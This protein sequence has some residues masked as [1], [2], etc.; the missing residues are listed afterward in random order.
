MVS[1]WPDPHP[2][3]T[4]ANPSFP[5][6][7]QLRAAPTTVDHRC[8]STIGDI[9]LSRSPSLGW[10]IKAPS[11]SFNPAKLV[12]KE[13]PEWLP[14]IIH[15]ARRPGEVHGSIITQSICSSI[16]R[17][18]QASVAGRFRFVLQQGLLSVVSD[19]NWRDGVR[20]RWKSVCQRKEKVWEISRDNTCDSDLKRSS[21][22]IQAYEK[23]EN[24]QW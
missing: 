16:C 12:G 2:P 3:T 23:R 10:G 15:A 8:Y 5:P 20:R 7:R 4:S 22:L 24:S 17:E 14:F 13:Q 21:L 19:D 9:N 11:V 1:S 18:E 6:F